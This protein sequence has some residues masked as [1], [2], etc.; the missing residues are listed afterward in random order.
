MHRA[1]SGR[2]NIKKEGHNSLCPYKIIKIVGAYFPIS[3]TKPEGKSKKGKID[4]HSPIRSRTGFMGMTVVG[5]YCN[6]PLQ[7][8]KEY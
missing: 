3:P 2:K 4:S 6:K 8:L 1:Q 7:T 5:A